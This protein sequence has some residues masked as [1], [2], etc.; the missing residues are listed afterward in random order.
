MSL[1]AI[2]KEFDFSTKFPTWIIAYCVD[3]NSWFCTNQRFFYYEYPKEFETEHEAIEYFRNHVP[4]FSKLT[5]EMYPNKNSDVFLEN[6]REMW[7][8]NV[9]FS[10]CKKLSEVVI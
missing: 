3:T 4:E 2:P 8:G 7:T 6:T 9:N 5:R 1:V 10:A